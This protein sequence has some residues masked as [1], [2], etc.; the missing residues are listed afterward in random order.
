MLPFVVLAFFFL[1]E[2]SKNPRLRVRVFFSNAIQ[3][4]PRDNLVKSIRKFF[5]C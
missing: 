5:F 2:G 3:P 1:C 4:D